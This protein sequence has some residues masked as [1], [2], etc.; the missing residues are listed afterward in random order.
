MGTACLSK[1]DSS[2]GQYLV[3]YCCPTLPTLQFVGAGR[4]FRGD[5][6]VSQSFFWSLNPPPHTLLY[7]W[8]GSRKVIDCPV[9]SATRGISPGK[10]ANSSKLLNDYVRQ[11]NA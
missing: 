4:D 6:I 1:S 5:V 7:P 3:Q 8:V 2:C 11:S 9:M 10:R